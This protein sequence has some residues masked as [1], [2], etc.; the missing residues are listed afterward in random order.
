M[1]KDATV[2]R[3]SPETA[4]IAKETRGIEWNEAGEIVRSKEWMEERVVFLQTKRADS[5]KRVEN[6]DADIAVLQEKLSGENNKN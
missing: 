4:S 6:I 1:A 2:S 5:L 3:R